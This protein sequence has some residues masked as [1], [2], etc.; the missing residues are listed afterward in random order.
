MNK[1]KIN[2]LEPIDFSGI[3]SVDES[4]KNMGKGAIVI[5][6]LE[7]ATDT[8]TSALLGIE[9]N[10]KYPFWQNLGVTILGG[11]IGGIVSQLFSL[12]F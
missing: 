12:I 1:K 7:N 10:T 4:I 2:Q 6:K 8:K 11:T 5:P 3:K 9:K